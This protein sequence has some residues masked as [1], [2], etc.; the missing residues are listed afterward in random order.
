MSPIAPL[1]VLIYPYA[2]DAQ[3]NNYLVHRTSSKSAAPKS[4]PR[5]SNTALQKV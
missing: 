4:F 1:R 3:A 5:T 2:V